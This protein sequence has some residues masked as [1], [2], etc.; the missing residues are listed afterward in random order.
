M[1]KKIGLVYDLRTDYLAQGYS[2][3][4]V[5]EFDS[6][7][8][9][10]ALQSAISSLRYSVERIG[11]AKELA[12]QLVAG[13]RWDM[14]F[15]I[16]EGIGGRTR[17][18]YVPA[19]L[20]M[21]AVPYTF[22]DALVCALTLDKS[23]AKKIVSQ[24]SLRSPAFRVIRTPEDIAFT[25]LQY[26]LFAKPLAEGT[27]KGITANSQIE[28]YSRLES[29]CIELL[30]AYKQPVL[31][32]EFLPGREF[33]VGVIGNGENVRAIGTMEIEILSSSEP[34]VYSFLNKEQCELR[35]N[36]S[37]LSE[38]LL[39]AEVEKLAVDS[40][41]ALEC[42]D[43]GRVDIRCDAGGVPCFIEINPLAGLHPTHS[44]LCI[45][46]TQEGIS[47]KSL[48]SEILENAFARQNQGIVYSC[49]M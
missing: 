36:Y 34:A 8:T 13:K 43:C 30:I 46:A 6:E 22:S 26:P 7:E 28:T 19:I 9:I 21:Y 1:I 16:A 45:I 39:K 3:L 4:D 15:N 2:E 37:K 33:T 31:V 48:I 32:E 20:D 12:K 5:A 41:K 42:R 29:V 18:S 23:M 38:P 47:Y 11:N 14:V 35:V 24:A 10:D 17:E 44:D 49:A 27:G 25:D 40:Y